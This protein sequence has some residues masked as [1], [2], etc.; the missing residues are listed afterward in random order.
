MV[1]FRLCALL[2]A[3]ASVAGVAAAEVQ[4]IGRYSDWRVYTERV[5][6]ELICF[7][8]T[9]PEDVAPKGFDHGDVNF[10]VAT[11]KSKGAVNQPSL[12][13]GYELRRD[14]APR[15]EVGRDGYSMYAVGNEAFVDDSRERSLVEALKKGVEL[16]VEA[17]ASDRRTAYTFSLRGSS[18][19]IEKARALCR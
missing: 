11:W 14:L 4:A 17:A 7:A 13:V 3:S 6:G 19:A 8:S 2:I 15:A 5:G 16:R 10:Y 1:V 12:K 9:E 18:D